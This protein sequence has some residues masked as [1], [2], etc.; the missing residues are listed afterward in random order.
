MWQVKFT[1]AF[2]NE[3]CM[4]W[5][6]D[7][8]V[9]QA[10]EARRHQRES[11]ENENVKESESRSEG[12]PAGL[13]MKAMDKAFKQTMKQMKGSGHMDQM[14]ELFRKLME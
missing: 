9:N 5:L 2:E 7:K 13:D 8:H 14:Q 12:I 11:W 4:Q 10:E 3:Y 6:D 1:E